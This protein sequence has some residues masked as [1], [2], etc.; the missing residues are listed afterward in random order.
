M[1]LLSVPMQKEALTV[2]AQFFDPTLRC[3]QFQYFQMALTPEKFGKILEISKSMKGPFKM[4]GYHPTVEDMFI[5][6]A[7]MKLTYKPI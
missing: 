7:S 2:L 6:F 5:T 1:D 3:F 4:I